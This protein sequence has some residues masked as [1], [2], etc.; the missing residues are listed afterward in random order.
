MLKGLP[1]TDSGHERHTLDIYHGGPKPAN[2]LQ[3]VVF[4]IHGGGWE[5]GD[6]SMIDGGGYESRAGDGN[7][8]SK[9]SFF[10]AEGFVFCSTNYRLLRYGSWAGTMDASVD[11]RIGTM[12]E[13][14]AKAMRWVHDHAAEYGGDGDRMVVMGH[15][16]GAQL[17]ALLCTDA[18]LLQREGLD[19]DNV[20]KACI[21]IDG[22]TY[23]VPAVIAAG[24]RHDKKFGELVEQQELSAALHVR[25]ATKHGRQCAIPPFLALHIYGKPDG[26]PHPHNNNY[27][28]AHQTRILADALGEAGVRCEVVGT[29]NKD[30][31]TLD[32]EIGKPGDFITCVVREFLQSVLVV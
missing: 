24:S 23:D 11:I 13:D 19:L 31:I 22:D 1:Y 3:P 20:V 4:Y 25:A 16:A 9:P 17:A 32:S 7:D 2:G 29:A 30:H 18:R 5:G 8:W 28:T 21:P 6:S 27:C 14:C 15:S 10:V 26:S 12:A